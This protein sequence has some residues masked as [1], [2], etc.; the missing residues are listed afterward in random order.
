MAKKLFIG[1]EEH[2]EKKVESKVV[3]IKDPLDSIN[4]WLARVSKLKLKDKVV[5][6]RLFATMINAGI[7]IVKAID[8]LSQQVDSAK[9]KVILEDI[10]LKVKKGKNLSTALEE[11]YPDEFSD[12]EIG[13][14][15]AGEASGKLNIVLLSLATNVEKSS[16][17]TKKLKGAMMYPV[18][19]FILLIAALCAVMTLVI[20]NIKEMFASFDAELP[21]ATQALIDFS[22][23]M[24]AKSGPF[25]LMNVWNIVGGI[26]LFVLGVQSFKKTK[27][28]KVMWDSFLLILPIF[29][30]LN[31]KI[32]IAKMCRGIATLTSSGI[33]IIRTLVICADMIGNELYKMRVLQMA[34][35][36]KIGMRMADNLRGDHKY[37][38]PIV[39]SMISIGEQTAQIDKITMK[40]AEFFEEDVE[41]LIRNISALLEPI[42]IVVVGLSVAALVIAIMLPILSLSDLAGGG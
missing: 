26:V 29:G 9:L 13:M 30:K 19:V 3:K 38:S 20:P 11:D 1:A 28:G 27:Q 21:W 10:S 33:P 4:Q 17:L 23:F 18:L 41:D 32:A 2:Q 35:D 34:E 8:I 36:V 31:K 25:N 15:K 40:I 22:D 16:S 42:I 14:L 37:F 7:S 6:Y 12:A 39:I 5:F 24:I